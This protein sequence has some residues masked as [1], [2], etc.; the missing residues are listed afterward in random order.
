MNDVDR[1]DRDE[2]EAMF[3]RR[4]TDLHGPVH[5]PADL[6]TRTHRR[7]RWTV[8]VAGLTVLTVV[9]TSLAVVGAITRDRKPMP[10]NTTQPART[11]DILGVRISAPAG[12]TL[13]EIGTSPVGVIGPEGGGKPTTS[14]FPLLQLSNFEPTPVGST[15]FPSGC[16]TAGDEPVVLTIQQLI[17]RPRPRTDPGAWPVELG[18]PP[19]HDQE[20][21]CL[22]HERYATWR[23]TDGRILEAWLGGTPGPDMDRAER[24]FASLSF[25][26]P[27]RNR[28]APHSS[29]F[30][31]EI[32]PFYVLDA[33]KT[34]NQSWTSVAYFTSY[35]ESPSRLC[36]ALEVN[37]S[38]LPSQ[39]DIR[40]GSNPSGGS[41]LGVEPITAVATLDGQTTGYGYGAMAPPDAR[42]AADVTSG[43]ML[44]ENAVPL[45]AGF[46]VPLAALVFVATPDT[47]GLV[48]VVSPDDGLD[49]GSH[50]IELGA[51]VPHLDLNIPPEGTPPGAA[52]AFDAFGARFVLTT[53]GSL[54]LLQ[55]DG[56]FGPGGGGGSGSG[57]ESPSTPDVATTGGSGG[58]ASDPASQ[59]VYGRAPAGSTSVSVR[60]SYGVFRGVV[61]PASVYES[62]ARPY[63][64]VPVGGGGP[65]TVVFEDAEH[66]ELWRGHVGPWT[67][68]GQA[69]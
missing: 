27:A 57:S 44:Y 10:A 63:F 59:F 26:T 60:T 41:D 62:D 3:R 31:S 22:L 40:L 58:P 64:A 68:F 50:R 43:S 32:G 6:V 20:Y 13:L 16:N 66:V 35:P 49:L 47:E 11:A 2:L 24:I 46:D 15:V 48:R 53:Y 14:A 51:G 55:D 25:P 56:T 8:A 28:N 42:A 36:L 52:G 21:D 12:W 23:T 29:R 61:F 39:C 45:P 17:S 4:E 18:P 69:P 9:A 38:F 34:G 30:G 67:D 1:R 54:Q 7:Q 33:G 65:G 37:G 5:V 19:Y